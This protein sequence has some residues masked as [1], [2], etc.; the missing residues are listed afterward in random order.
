M[1]AIEE[2]VTKELERARENQ[3][4]PM[5]WSG[6]IEG[7]ISALEDVLREINKMRKRGELPEM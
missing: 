5:F 1:N 7:K 4:S 6:H 2:Y 3:K